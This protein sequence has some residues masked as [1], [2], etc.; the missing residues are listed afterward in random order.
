MIP[1]QPS[2]S[3][4]LLSL[5]TLLHYIQTFNVQN[6]IEKSI[7]FCLAKVFEV[8]TIYIKNIKEA[9]C[10]ESWHSVTFVNFGTQQH[11]SGLCKKNTKKCVYLQ[12]SSP[13]WPTFCVLYDKVH[14]LEKSTPLL[15]V[16]IIWAVSI[17]RTVHLIPPTKRGKS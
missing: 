9:K 17:L 12:L 4:Q 8:P 2:S 6:I 13:N 10:L 5:P 1:N 3:I 15:V 16:T 7:L 14:R 11:N